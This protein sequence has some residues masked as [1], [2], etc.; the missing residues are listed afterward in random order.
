[1]LEHLVLNELCAH[2]PRDRVFYWRD[3]QKHEV[4]FVAR[5]GRSRA[6]LAIECKASA[7]K[8]NPAGMQAFRRRHPAGDNIVVTLRETE[9]FEK[10]FGGVGVSFV[11]LTALPGALPARGVSARL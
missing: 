9:R 4:D 6:P 1:M 2:V 7:S 3:K 5:L 11:P 8:F 10:T